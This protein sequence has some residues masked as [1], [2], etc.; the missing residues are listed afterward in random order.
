MTL[1]GWV[2]RAKARMR[3][4]VLLFLLGAFA[5]VVLYPFETTVVPEWR[6]RI[7]D[8]AGGQ[9]RDFRS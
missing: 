7:V 2:A 5:I 6:V 9:C 8:E 1:L 3:K 4:L